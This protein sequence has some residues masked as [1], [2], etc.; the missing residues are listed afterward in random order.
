MKEISSEKTKIQ[1]K[2]L[3]YYQIIGGIIGIG[4]VIWFVSQTTFFSVLKILLL[5]VGVG[6]YSFSIYCGY[7]LLNSTNKESFR[8][9]AINQA[10][11]I[12]SFTLL[13]FSY[14]YIAGVEFIIGM[15]LTSETL[16]TFNF[17]F[18]SSEFQISV[19]DEDKDIAKMGINIVPILIM[20]FINKLEQKIKDNQ[21]VFDISES[22]ILDDDLIE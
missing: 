8:L 3:A 12:L 5:G 10:L 22:K 2:G 4:F 20:Y 6:L 1:I 7:Q 9:S 15:N 13:G 19:G 18:F 11:Q 16:F 14:K 17:A 21:S